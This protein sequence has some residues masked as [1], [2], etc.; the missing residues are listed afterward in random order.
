MGSPLSP[1]LYNVYTKGLADLNQNGLSRVLTLA[2]D[3]LIYKTTRDTQE[4][5]QAVQQQ[6]ENVS[7]WCQDTGSL[8][9]PSKAQTLWC[10]LDN[11]AA[12]KVMPAVTF[13]GAVVE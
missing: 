8:I 7:Q 2:D 1:V 10:T 13:D 4:A 12:G 9:N 3:G 5:A 11:K 6:L